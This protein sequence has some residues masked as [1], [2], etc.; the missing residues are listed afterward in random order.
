MKT[1]TTSHHLCFR[2]IYRISNFPA[3]TCDH[4][5]SD[6]LRLFFQS[7]SK[8]INK[9][10]TTLIA[11]LGPVIPYYSSAGS[12]RPLPPEPY[13]GAF[14]AWTLDTLPL[15]RVTTNLIL[16]HI[17]KPSPPILPFSHLGITADN[18]SISLPP[19]FWTEQHSLNRYLLPVCS[20]LVF[21][22]LHNTLGCR[23]KYQ[24]STLCV[25]G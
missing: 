11:K 18:L 16:R 15:D 22:L 17:E 7:R 24:L 6:S 13:L 10:A 4:P 2:H 19:N 23:Y 21:R 25:H 12:F 5:T 14:D 3:G 20:D 8:H 1:I 9:V